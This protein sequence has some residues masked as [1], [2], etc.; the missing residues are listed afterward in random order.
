MKIS[1]AGIV[2]PLNKDEMK[3]LTKET[4]ETLAPN[5]FQQTGNQPFGSVDLW[6]VRKSYRTMVSMRRFN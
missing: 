4:K 1:T 2:T 6:R 3:E 5:A